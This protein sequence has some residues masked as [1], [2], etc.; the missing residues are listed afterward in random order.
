MFF[1]K[2]TYCAVTKMF[3]NYAALH[4]FNLD[5]AAACKICLACKTCSAMIPATEKVF[6]NS[7]LAFKSLKTLFQYSVKI[8]DEEFENFKKTFIMYDKVLHVECKLLM[9]RCCR[10]S[11][12]W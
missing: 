8:T 9:L 7:F 3:E 1:S 10:I 11:I 5:Q 2:F 12:S 4:V 6:I